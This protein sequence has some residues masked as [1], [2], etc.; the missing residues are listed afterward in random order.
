VN[1]QAQPGP[2]RLADS[3]AYARL[4]LEM[5]VG[6]RREISGAKTKSLGPKCSE[7]LATPPSER[8]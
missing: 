8:Q 5:I 2:A 4:E 1:F 7:V 6:S 3:P